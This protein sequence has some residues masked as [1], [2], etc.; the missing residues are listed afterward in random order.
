MIKIPWPFRHLRSTSVKLLTICVWI[1]PLQNC[2][3]WMLIQRLWPSSCHLSWVG[4][5][6]LCSRNIPQTTYLAGLVSPWHNNGASTLGLI[7]RWPR[8]EMKLL[9]GCATLVLI[10]VKWLM[11]QCSFLFF[12]SF[13]PYNPA[14]HF[15]NV[16]TCLYPNHNSH[17]I[18][19]SNSCNPSYYTN[20]IA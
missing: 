5:S 13:T 12:I 7:Y 10:F 16:V 19:F 8:S 1:L 17:N 18:K 11:F 6:V 2:S 3:H 15:H 9:S 4:S 20:I 14:L